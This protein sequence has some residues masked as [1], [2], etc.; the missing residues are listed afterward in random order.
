MTKERNTAPSRRVSL[1]LCAA[2]LCSAVRLLAQDA[3]VVA[4]DAWVRLPQSTTATTLYL[5]LENRST[6]R[7]AVVSASSDAAE[8]VEMYEMKMVRTVMSH[9]SGRDRH[10]GQG[11]T[12]LNP[13][14]FHLML[15]GLKQKPA[16]GDTLTVALKLDDGTSVLAKAVF[17]KWKS[18]QTVGLGRARTRSNS[19]TTRV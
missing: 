15:F 5:V 11:K 18:P 8:K 14:G 6:E 1:T 13:N 4:H 17:R 12:S 3:A 2:G 7:R 10:T 16:V 19:R 9:E